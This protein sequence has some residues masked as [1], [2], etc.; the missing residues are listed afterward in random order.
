MSLNRTFY[1]PTSLWQYL[2]QLNTKK[3]I[4]LV[5]MKGPLIDSI[6]VRQEV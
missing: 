3:C 2:A 1:T 5:N 6:T 4:I